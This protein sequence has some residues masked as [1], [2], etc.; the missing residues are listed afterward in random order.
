MATKL[1]EEDQD[2]GRFLER[3]RYGQNVDLF[4]RHQVNITDDNNDADI[5]DEVDEEVIPNNYVSESD[6]RK[7]Y[8]REVV[9]RK[10]GKP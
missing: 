2:I 5:D 4:V 3:V 9:F 7:R 1:F 10:I 6:F 8:P